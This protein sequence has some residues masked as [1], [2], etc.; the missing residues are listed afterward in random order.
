MCSFLIIRFLG[1]YN[2]NFYIITYEILL[3]IF[4]MQPLVDNLTYLLGS[5]ETENYIY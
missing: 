5:I 1:I 3:E 4:Q 2:L